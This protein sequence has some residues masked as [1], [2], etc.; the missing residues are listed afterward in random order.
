MSGA[1]PDT[2]PRAARPQMG[3]R[4]DGRHGSEP[5]LE[6][7]HTDHRQSTLFDPSEARYGPR[8]RATKQLRKLRV[9][10]PRCY[11][12]SLYLFSFARGAS[13]FGEA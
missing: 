4:G 5:W 1:T 9:Y 7:R 6:A 3:R 2:P 10:V 12:L 13:R 11:T 8:T